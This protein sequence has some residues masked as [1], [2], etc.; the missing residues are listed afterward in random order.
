MPQVRQ[1][2]A[3]RAKPRDGNPDALRSAL[4]ALGAPLF[5]VRANVGR[6]QLEPTLVKALVAARHEGVLFRVLPVV[7]EKNRRHL[8]VARLT[9]LARRYGVSRELG[10]LLEMT[11]K[12][13]KDP[14]LVKQARTLGLPT[15]RS[16][17]RTM[18]VRNRFERQRADMLATDTTLRWKVALNV[19]E[20]SLKE[21]LVKHHHE[22]SVV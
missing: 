14:Q 4:A 21:F 13:L 20:D 6:P 2:T 7:V 11:G 15:K 10:L 1:P 18:L 16:S 5:G 12:L 8:N 3:R 17:V 9:Q 19:S 22:A